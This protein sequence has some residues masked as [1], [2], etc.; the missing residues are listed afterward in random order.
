MTSN[1]KIIN[2]F[3]SNW[4]SVLLFILVVGLAFLAYR[5][6]S[7]LSKNE[8]MLLDKYTEQSESFKKQINEINKINEER[9]K[10]QEELLKLYDKKI[11]EIN[12]QYKID[13][14]EIAEKQKNLQVKIVVDAKK[15]PNTLVKKVEETFGIPCYDCEQ[16]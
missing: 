4:I 16:Q 2:W 1:E 7:F 10:Q 14:A 5:Q 12:R 11:Q 9:F 13:L 15:D 3:K 8:Q 6:F